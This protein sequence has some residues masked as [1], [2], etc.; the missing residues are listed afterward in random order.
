MAKT[1]ID[2]DLSSKGLVCESC[3]QKL[4]NVKRSGRRPSK[5]KKNDRFLRQNGGAYVHLNDWQDLHWEFIDSSDSLRGA[6]ND[7]KEQVC[8]SDAEVYRKLLDSV[9]Y[10]V[11]TVEHLGTRQ[12]AMEMMQYCN[13]DSRAIKP[14]S[15]GCLIISDAEYVFFW[16]IDEE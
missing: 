13:F 11:F 1:V 3:G 10:F 9:L 5:P 6:Y 8:G 14:G 15:V 12:S 16:K 2:I 4:P 7:L